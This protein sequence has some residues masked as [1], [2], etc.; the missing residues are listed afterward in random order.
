MKNFMFPLQRIKKIIVEQPVPALMFLSFLVWGFAFRHFIFD[1]NLPLIS[2][3]IS[4]F[5]HS[6]FYVDNLSRGVYPLW[7]PTWS[8]GSPNEFFLRRFGSFTPLLSLSVFF[9]KIGFNYD[10]AYRLYLVVY[11][12]LEMI[13]FYKL[14][15]CLLRDRRMAFAAFLLF[16]FSSLGVRLFD[17]YLNLFLA[18]MIWFF[19]F[20]LSSAQKPEKYSILGMTFCLM[21]IATTYIPFYFLIILLSFLVFVLLFYFDEVKAAV[22]RYWKFIQE[23][24]VF[25]FMCILFLF[26][27]LLPGLMLYK[28]GGSGGFVLP[29]R[30]AGLTTGNP[31]EV[32]HSW[33]TSWA[34]LEEIFYS[35]VYWED[36]THFNFAVLYVPVF[37]VILLGLGILAAATRRSLFFLAWGVFILLLSIPQTPVY[38]FLKEHVFFFK[39]F[40]NLHFFLWLALLPIGILFLTS[41]L[42][43]IL[44]YKPRTK[45]ERFLWGSIL[46]LAHLG[47]L[48]FLIRRDSVVIASC[49]AVVLSFIFFIFYFAGFAQRRGGMPLLLLLGVISLEPAQVYFYLD[50]NTA[51]T[52]PPTYEVEFYQH[53][54]N[55]PYLDFTYLRGPKRKE[56]RKAIRTDERGSKPGEYYSPAAL[57]YSVP[58]FSVLYQNVDV[59]ILRNYVNEKFI[60]YDRVEFL[61]DANLDFKRIE[62]NFSENVNTAFVADASVQVP[63]R[64]SQSFEPQAQRVEGHSAEF[65]VLSFDSNTIKFRTNFSQPKFIVYND[66]FHNG[67]Q[68]FLNGKSLPLVR[69]NVAFKGMWVPAGENV[70]LLRFGKASL[71]V[72]NIFLLMLFGGIFLYLVFVG[73]RPYFLTHHRG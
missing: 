1:T 42:Q 21:I 12:F 72:F 22:L 5:D 61:D 73:L 17:A 15:Q 20:L 33:I 14:A 11:Y 46:L 59:E 7:N 3:A 2:D 65:Q 51:R 40:R 29:K 50:R 63:S 9:N 38:Q 8:C 56:V 32:D 4:Y 24:K 18:P 57:Y 45:K 36:L 41:Q 64:E 6:K 31:I 54:Y 39:Y 66:S 28:A 13:G 47:F 10:V 58:S 67:W 49:L 69:A 35:A 68:G 34:I 30:H 62:K 26:L 70:V 71:Y 37:A 48:I 55:Q 43:Q 53:R 23:N 27:A 19:Y 25:I 52:K 44:E 60:V 16:L